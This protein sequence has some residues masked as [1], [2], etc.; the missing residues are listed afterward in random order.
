MRTLKSLHTNTHRVQNGF[1]VAARPCKIQQIKTFVNILAQ[2]LT[3][4]VKR[5]TA[6]LFVDVMWTWP[7]LK[8]SSHPP[9]S[10]KCFLASLAS[11][12]SIKFYR[13]LPWRTWMLTICR[14]AEHFR[15]HQGTDVQC[16][17]ITRDSA[18]QQDHFSFVF[19][20]WNE[21]IE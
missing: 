16:Q 2:R 15:F 5:S 12:G 7:W 10:H 20:T 3:L 18:A 17:Q 1:R 6:C 9:E 11:D 8:R 21:L 14:D 19:A 4:T 13:F